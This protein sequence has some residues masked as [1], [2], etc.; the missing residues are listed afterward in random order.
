VQSQQQS[1]R[2]TY[3]LIVFGRDGMEL[4]LETSDVRFVLPSVEIPRWERVAENLTAA[5]ERDL[6]CEAICLLTPSISS[7]DGKSQF[8]HYEVMECL[9][10]ARHPEKAAWHPIHL[11]TVDSF[12]DVNEFRVL[13]RCIHELENYKRDSRSPFAGRGWLGELR[14][15][16]A[17]ILRGTGVEL[18]GPLRQYNA[19]PSFSLIRFETSGPALWFKAVGEPNL[20]E[21]PIT[22]KLAELFPKFTPPILSTKPEWNGWLSREVSGTNLGDTKHWNLWQQAATDLAKLQ[23]ESIPKCGSLLQAGTHDLRFDVLFS[24]IDPFFDLVARLMGE[25]PKV[26]PAILSR[27][28]LS[29][30]R[31]LV[32]DALTKL[33]DLGI[34]D[35]LGHLD[36]NPW[37]VIV[38]SGG[39]VFLDWAEAYVGPPFISLE[40]L[41]QHFQRE[42]GSSSATRSQV[43]EAYQR[44]WHEV[45]S[46]D[47]IGEALTLTPLAAVFAYAAGTDALKDEEKLRD[48]RI[49]GYLRSLARRMNR[50][51]IELS[52][53]RSPCL[54]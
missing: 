34:P 29:R 15:W 45:V 26:P 19:S 8:D 13:E 2:E 32:D 47:H 4:L 24:S 7:E 37:N 10:H 44:S 20:R 38:S 43:V 11:L 39:S 48:P 30:I 46:H 28:Q 12:K 51:A 21:F 40:Y 25:Q 52:E 18:T 53:Q 5:L 22:L 36:L 3:R 27:E 16:A 33:Q 41:L 49:A 35:T 23:I 50:E 1:E 31:V 6:G 54:S 42:I 14:N 17:D 9:Q